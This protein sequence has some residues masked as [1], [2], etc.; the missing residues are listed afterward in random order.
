MVETPNID[1]KPDMKKLS[2]MLLEV[3]DIKERNMQIFEAYK[4]G[5]SQ[6]GIT[7]VLGLAQPTVNAI[8]KRMKGDSAITITPLQISILDVG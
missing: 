1:K 7:K 8:V 3:K 5:Y 4:Q 6:H 2:K